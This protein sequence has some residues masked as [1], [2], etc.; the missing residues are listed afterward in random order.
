[1][2]KR[3]PERVAVFFWKKISSFTGNRKENDF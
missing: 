2:E 1:M 3:H